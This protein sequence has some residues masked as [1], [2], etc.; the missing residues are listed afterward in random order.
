MEGGNRKGPAFPETP[1]ESSQMEDE[2]TGYEPVFSLAGL[3][4]GAVYLDKTSQHAQHIAEQ[5]TGEQE[6]IG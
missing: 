4:G 1:G 5:G 3:C 2:T 6:R